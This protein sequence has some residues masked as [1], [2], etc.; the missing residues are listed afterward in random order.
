[1]VKKFLNEANALDSDVDSNKMK[2][3]NEYMFNNIKKELKATVTWLYFGMTFWPFTGMSR[4]GSHGGVNRG[5]QH[6]AEEE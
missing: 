4:C 6:C 1:M 2:T 3:R 5:H